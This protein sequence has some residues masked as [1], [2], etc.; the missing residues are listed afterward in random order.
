MRKARLSALSVLGVP[1]WAER[2]ET[3]K[4][5]VTLQHLPRSPRS[6]P[7]ARAGASWLC[8]GIMF[9]LGLKPCPATR[10]Q[11]RPCCVCP[12]RETPDACICGGCSCTQA[13][14]FGG[15]TALSEPEHSSYPNP[16]ASSTCTHI[17]QHS[18]DIKWMQ[19]I[20]HGEAESELTEPHGELGW[21]GDP[22]LQGWVPH[23]SKCSQFRDAFSHSDAGT[24]ICGS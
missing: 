20:L 3:G 14:G 6:L 11:Q 18:Q 5:P 12:C 19:G 17:P 4:A 1:G 13:Q 22:G 15:D 10:A 23:T 16:A 9:F 8:K 24:A 2:G 7:S 21:G